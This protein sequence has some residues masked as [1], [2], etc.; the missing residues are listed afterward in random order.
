MRDEITQLAIAAGAGDMDA[1][2]LLKKKSPPMWCA[3]LEYKGVQCITDGAQLIELLD[4]EN[5]SYSSLMNINPTIIDFPEDTDE[6]SLVPNGDSYESRVTNLITMVASTGTPLLYLGE[7]IRWIL[8]Q[9]D[10]CILDGSQDLLDISNEVVKGVVSLDV[11]GSWLVQSVCFH[12]SNEEGLP[13]EEVI[14]GFIQME[15]K[16]QTEFMQNVCEA[17]NLNINFQGE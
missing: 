11:D 14:E 17:M 16:D 9:C 12:Y 7:W 15:P 6:I 3:T 1:Y 8:V 2:Q 10:K 13:V 5:S 4:L